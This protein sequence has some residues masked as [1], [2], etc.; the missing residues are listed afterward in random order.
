MDARTMSTTELLELDETVRA[1][2][3]RRAIALLPHE[4]DDDLA[5]EA[6]N[7]SLEQ[8]G[9]AHFEEVYDRLRLQPEADL[10][11]LLAQHKAD[12]EEA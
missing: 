9:D 11:A 2:I 12:D 3:K 5:V 6:T 10:L 1:E 8:E 7:S 4:Y